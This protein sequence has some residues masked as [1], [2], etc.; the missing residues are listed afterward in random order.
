MLN[1]IAEN[2]DGVLDN[3]DF[4]VIPVLNPEGYAYTW[5]GRRSRLWRKN[6]RR[7]NRFCSGVDINRNFEPGRSTLK[8]QY[9]WKS[10]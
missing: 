3:F 5:E 1:R 9:G 4:Y 6:R 2:V 10:D 7:N 8:V